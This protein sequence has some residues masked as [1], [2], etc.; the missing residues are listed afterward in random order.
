MTIYCG[1]DWA[2]HHHDVAI[3]DDAGKVLATRR[4]GEDAAGLTTLLMMLAEHA[5]ADAGAGVSG[6]DFVAVD[7]AIETGR[8]L[9]VSSV[10]AAGHRVFE[11]NPKASSRY[12]DRYSVSGSKSDARDAQVLAHLLRTDRDRHRP[13]PVDSEQARALGVLARAQQDAVWAILRDA[14]RLRAVLW[15]F[16]PAALQAFPNLHIVSAIT[17]LTAAPTPGAAA[18]LSEAELRKLLHAARYHAPRDLPG[19]LHAI[20][21]ATQLR[22]PPAVEAAMGQVVVAILRTMAATAA[23]IRE[24][25][26]ALDEHFGQHPDAEILRSLPGL[27]VVLGARVLGEFGDDPTR[28]ADAASRRAYAGSAPIT[29]ASGKARVVL[30]RRARNKRLCDACRWWAFLSTQHSPGAESYYRRR[31]TAGDGHEA[32]LRRLANKLLGQLHHCLDRRTL[33][34]EDKAWTQLQP[35]EHAA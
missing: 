34:D 32:A 13:M 2:A 24:L 12:R 35:G 31:R 5:A 7:V 14:A 17:V 15:E 26:K 21:T 29:R 33:Y 1:I 19:K 23:S 6:G 8:G 22:Q 18:L 4:I 9:L 16:Y 10:R 20:F 25:E 28:F 11:I 27:G 30:L 3:V